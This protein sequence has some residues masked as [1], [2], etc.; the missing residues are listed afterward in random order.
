MHRMKSFLFGLALLPFSLFAQSQDYMELLLIAEIASDS[1]YASLGLC[2]R[3]YQ[4]LEDCNYEDGR[5]MVQLS[6]ILSDDA[7]RQASLGFESA[8]S[9]YKIAKKKRCPEA[10]EKCDIALEQ[11]RFARQEIDEAKQLIVQ[12]ERQ[13]IIINEGRYTDS[14]NELRFGWVDGPKDYYVNTARLAILSTY[15]HLKLAKIAIEE[16]E[17]IM[18]D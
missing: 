11:L 1:T 4:D 7:Y 14:F 16:A 15:D 2:D 10:K 9:A 8:R 5:D 3:S 13:W 18:C 17:L 6:L 12:I